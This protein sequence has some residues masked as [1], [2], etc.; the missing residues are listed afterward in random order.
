LPRGAVVTRDGETVAFV[1]KNNRVLKTPVHLGRKLDTMVEILNGVEVGD[2][3][4]LAP[5][6]KIKNGVK[7]RVTQE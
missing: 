3:V 2:Q 1:V 6:D 7:V 5:L 4:V